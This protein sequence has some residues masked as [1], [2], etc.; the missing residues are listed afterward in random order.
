MRSTECLALLSVPGT[1]AEP[2]KNLSPEKMQ[3]VVLGEIDR[4]SGQ[5]F[6][7][8]LSFECPLNEL[9]VIVEAKAEETGE[10][11]NY[12]TTIFRREAI[13][14]STMERVVLGAPEALRRSPDELG[15]AIFANEW[16]CAMCLLKTGA[17]APGGSS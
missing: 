4:I 8:A 3:D 1:K 10:R 7:M 5:L 2:M 15:V 14:G 9:L 13:E 12:V 11:V 17:T 6:S 16:S